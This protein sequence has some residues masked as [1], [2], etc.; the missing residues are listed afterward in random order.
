MNADTK[1]LDAMSHL[2]DS[3][4]KINYVMQG[5]FMHGWQEGVQA[6]RERIKTIIREVTGGCG[7][8]DRLMEKIERR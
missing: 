4:K 5:A 1:M 3:R 7:N 2:M 8:C 6:E